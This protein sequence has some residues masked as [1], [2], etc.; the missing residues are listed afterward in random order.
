[1]TVLRGE[2][3][4]EWGRG[5][6][7]VAAP[8]GLSGGLPVRVGEWRMETKG[9]LCKLGLEYG[10]SIFLNSE[11]W[12][13]LRE[14]NHSTRQRPAHGNPLHTRKCRVPHIPHGLTPFQ[15]DSK[16]HE[17]TQAEELL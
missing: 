13:S 17:H 6:V 7:V 5:C 3:E 8:G 4:S 14:T 10:G 9:G 15:L 11:S 1:M 16:Q 2:W 12:S